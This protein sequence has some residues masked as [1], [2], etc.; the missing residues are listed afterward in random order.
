[1][2]KMEIY[3]PITR[4]SN[5]SAKPNHS[6]FSIRYWKLLITCTKEMFSIEI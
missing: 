6:P 2:L 5:S 3:S 4:W 1:M